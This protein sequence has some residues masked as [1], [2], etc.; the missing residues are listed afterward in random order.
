[1]PL[2]CYRLRPVVDVLY[3]AVFAFGCCTTR[4]LFTHLLHVY[5]V[6]LPVISRYVWFVY[7]CSVAVLLLYVTRCDVTHAYAFTYTPLRYHRSPRLRLRLPF[8]PLRLVTVTR[9]LPF[10]VAGYTARTFVAL[11]YVSLPRPHV[12]TVCAVTFVWFLVTRLRTVIG[13][14]VRF[15]TLVTCVVVTVTVC[16]LLHRYLFTFLPLICFTLVHFTIPLPLRCTPVGLR[17][18]HLPTTV[19]FYVV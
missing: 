12:P 15:T 8:L 4:Y 14:H 3:V 10:N 5:D 9:Y 6:T 16:V 1:L 7:I 19:A 17:T 11:F 2:R 13:L 18:P